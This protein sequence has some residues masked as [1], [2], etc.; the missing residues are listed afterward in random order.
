MEAQRHTWEPAEVRWCRIAR[1]IDPARERQGDD[2][3]AKMKRPAK[4]HLC[5]RS[6][7]PSLKSRE[8]VGPDGGETFNGEASTA[9][10]STVGAERVCRSFVR[11]AEQDQSKEPAKEAAGLHH[12]CKKRHR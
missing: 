8:D 9:G 7:V 5:R 12:L 2:H 3:V 11:G 6:K 4:N 10:V 1:R